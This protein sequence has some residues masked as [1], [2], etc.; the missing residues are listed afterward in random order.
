MAHT[1]TLLK[2]IQFISRFSPLRGAQFL[3]FQ[4]INGDEK[5]DEIDLTADTDDEAATENKISE[6][7][8]T[9]NALLHYASKFKIEKH[10]T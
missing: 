8:W 4:I 2:K 10:F 7:A 6:F 3:E 9:I 1:C 5:I